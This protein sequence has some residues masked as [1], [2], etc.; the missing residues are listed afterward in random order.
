MK[1]VI[2]NRLLTSTVNVSLVGCGGVGSQVLTGLAR[3]HSAL[4]ALGHPGGLEV[5]AY[6]MDTVSESN[7]GRQLFSPA[8]VGQ[9]KSTLLVHR[10]NSFF[11]L[12]WS[13]KPCRFPDNSPGFHQTP[14]IIISCVDTKAARREIAHYCKRNSV[15]Y[16]MDC[17]NNLSDG[18]V[19]LGQPGYGQRRKKGD[20]RLILPTVVDLYK[21]IMDATLPEADDGPSC[22]LAEALERQDL[23]IGQCIATFGL[24]LLWSLFRNG[25]LENHGFFVNLKAGRVAPL[26]IDPE[27][28]KRFVPKKK[29]PSR[30]KINK[31]KAA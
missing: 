23:F 8:D 30:S 26:P 4:I 5:T 31:A 2:D 19:I 14:H 1:H 18:Q 21:E 15:R 10:L 9:F 11:G 25:G 17:G 28:W 27:A 16:W 29:R 7:I 3:L 12:K 6:D 24:Q 22:S 20:D 13:A